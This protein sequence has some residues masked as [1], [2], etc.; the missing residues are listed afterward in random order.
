MFA[1]SEVVLDLKHEQLIKPKQYASSMKKEEEN[2]YVFPEI[3]DSNKKQEDLNG[4]KRLDDTY[5]F[6][7]F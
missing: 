2:S 4:T 3:N 6:T 5:H 1:P 7:H